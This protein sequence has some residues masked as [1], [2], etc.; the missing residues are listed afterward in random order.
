MTRL[1]MLVVCFVGASAGPARALPPDTDVAYAGNASFTLGASTVRIDGQ[2][3]HA[4]SRVL[5][6]RVYA[7]PVADA[8]ARYTGPPR[9][10]STRSPCAQRS[11]ARRS[12]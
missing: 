9:S 1:W 11:S 5:A 7:A 2:G 12:R 10:R 8:A 3:L 6:E 4:G